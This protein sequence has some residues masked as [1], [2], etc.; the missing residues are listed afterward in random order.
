MRCYPVSFV[1]M[2]PDPIAV[3]NYIIINN[4]VLY[5]IYL[6]TYKYIILIHILYNG[7]RADIVRFVVTCLNINTAVVENRGN[8]IAINA[9]EKYRKII[10]YKINY[11]LSYKL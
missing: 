3:L 8:R 10:D 11:S 2:I 5:Y 9:I 6:Y 7:F 1:S 4:R